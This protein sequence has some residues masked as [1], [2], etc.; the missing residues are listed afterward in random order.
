MRTTTSSPIGRRLAASAAAL[1]VALATGAAPVGASSAPHST[2]LTFTKIVRGATINWIAAGDPIDPHTMND[3]GTWT[4]QFDEPSFGGG[5][6]FVAGVF[7]TTQYGALG[8]FRLRWYEQALE[9]VAP[10][11]DS[12]YL[13]GTWEVVAGSGTGVYANLSGHG[14]WTSVRA[15]GVLTFSGD[16]KV[17]GL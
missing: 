4:I 9:P 8:T 3:G 15:N 7:H 12:D 2:T 5:L 17:L 13:T 11:A 16:L 1:A 14:L 10:G 6:H